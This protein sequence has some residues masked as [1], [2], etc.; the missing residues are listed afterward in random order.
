MQLR[1]EMVGITAAKTELPG[2]L[3]ALTNGDVE[4]V[5]IM[6]QNSPVAVLVTSDEYDRWKAVE[7]LNEELEDLIAVLEAQRSDN[8]VRVSLDEIKAK[9]GI[10]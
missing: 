5:V 3:R 10:D 9:Y 4:R 6:K 2:R 1:Q 8:G 7:A